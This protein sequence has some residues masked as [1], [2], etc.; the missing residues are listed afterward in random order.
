MDKPLITVITVC[1]NAAETIEQTILS[2]IS[3]TY[4]NIEYII[5]DGASTDGTIE[6][7]EKYRDKLSNFVSGRDKGIYDAMNKA[8]DLSHGKW[9]N[10]MNSGDT[11][12]DTKVIENVFANNI[13]E[14]TKII[15]GDVVRYFPNQKTVIQRFNNLQEGSI[16]FDLIH[17][18]TFIEGDVMRD[19]KYNIKYRISADADFFNEVYK[20]GGKFQYVPIAISNYESANGASAKQ[21]I[22]MFNEYTEIKGTK[23]CSMGWLFSYKKI[24]IQVLMMKILPQSIYN[25]IIHT[26]VNKV[27]IKKTAN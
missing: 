13:A 23:K 8:I 22:T 27:A 15:Y 18:S 24:H 2:V 17:Q 5:V 7:I 14:D 19:L 1:Y 6:I 9:I 11:F 4:T 10:F 3:Q 26:Y 16:Q 12:V 20:L 25:W 21:L